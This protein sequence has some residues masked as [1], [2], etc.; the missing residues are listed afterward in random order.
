MSD[1]D[2]LFA[3]EFLEKQTKLP[4]GCQNTRREYLVLFSIS[5]LSKINEFWTEHSVDYCYKK[6]RPLTTHEKFECEVFILKTH[7]MFCDHTTQEKFDNETIAGHF[8]F[9]F[10]ENWVSEIT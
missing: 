1:F 2:R 10:E 4:L 8:G 7:Q 9:M 5:S 6:P 3:I